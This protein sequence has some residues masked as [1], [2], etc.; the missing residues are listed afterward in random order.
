[1]SARLPARRPSAGAPAAG[2]LI[3]AAS[4]V[5]VLGGLAA[6]ILTSPGWPSGPRDLLLLE[7]LQGFLL[8]PC[9]SAFWLDVKI[10]V[11]VEV[12]VL[13]VGLALALIRTSRVPAL[14][15]CGFS[16][17]AGSTSFAGSP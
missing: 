1:M 9:L 17:P 8:R 11:V 6:L 4:T 12:V 15:R 10:F 14:F 3:A 5:I 2:Q 13:I 7:R 16:P